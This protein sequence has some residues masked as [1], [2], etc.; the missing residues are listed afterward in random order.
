MRIGKL[1][2]G[3]GAAL[4]V[5]AACAPAAQ[6]SPTTAPAKPALGK[7]EGPAAEKPAAKAEAKPAEKTAAKP[8]AKE[9]QK[10][11]VATAVSGQSGYIAVLI[12]AM[13]IDARHGLQIENQAMDFTEAA[14]ALKLGKST[15]AAMQPSTAVRLKK[16][17]TELRLIAPTIWSGNAWLVRK[18][19]PYQSFADLKGK[20]IGNFSRVTAAY[21]FSAVVAKEAGLDIEKD[22]ESIPAE[23][24]ALI[25]LLERGEVEAINMFEPHVTRLLLSDRYRVLVDFDTELERIFGAPP[26]KSS[27][28]VSKETAEKNPQVVQALQAA[29]RE[30]VE[31]IKSGK[32]EEFFRAN[33]QNLFGLKTE[34]EITA[35]YKRNQQNF[36]DKWG[37]E[38]FE[39]QNKILQ[40]GIDLGLLPSVS[41]LQELWSK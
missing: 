33:A 41:G 36:A 14:N 6:P 8:A 17:N 20:K 5:L 25:A 24:A 21:F 7:T 4:L 28:A 27:V 13:D 11:T 29:Y 16:D 18:D 23:T 9:P 38:F 31:M 12:D 34:E 26:L 35:G 32:D 40:R 1:I 30:G 22:F 15:A 39:S 3:T 2:A 10:V 19:A 37:A